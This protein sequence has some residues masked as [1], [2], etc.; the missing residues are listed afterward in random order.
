MPSQV[1]SFA[2]WIGDDFFFLDQN[3]WPVAREQ[4]RD[5][6]VADVLI[7]QTVKIRS[8]RLAGDSHIGIDWIP[9]LSEQCRVSSKWQSIICNCLFR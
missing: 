9:G 4:E 7:G 3:C 8:A 6:T 2:N 5:L 1:K